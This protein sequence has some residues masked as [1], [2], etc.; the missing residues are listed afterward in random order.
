MGFRA[1]NRMKLITLN[2]WGGFVRHPLLKFID[3]HRDIDIFCFQ[4]VYHNA[5][6]KISDDDKIVSLNIFSEIHTLLPQHKAY[7]RPVVGHG[8]G[9]GMLVKKE[10]AVLREGEMVIHNNPHYQGR[11]PTHSRKLQWLECG[12]NGKASAIVNVHGLWN[13]KGKGDCPERIAQSHA[14]RNF[15]QTIRVPKIVCGDFNLRPDTESLQIVEQGLSNWV[16]LSGVQ[17]TRTRLYTKE[18]RYAD[19]VLTSPEIVVHHFEVMKHE[20]SDHAPLMLEFSF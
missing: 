11:G 7:F 19:Y 20:V 3:A 8:Y 5:Q 1:V 16:K 18:E 6:H 13:G 17:S 10:I 15:I 12:I 2:I 9:I 4:E 14:I